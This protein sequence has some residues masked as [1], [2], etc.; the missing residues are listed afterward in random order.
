MLKLRH[1]TAALGAMALALCSISAFAVPVEVVRYA[2]VQA[3]DYG[4]QSAKLAADLA[5][6]DSAG[7]AADTVNAD[8][9]HEGHGFRQ[10]SASGKLR[11]ATQSLT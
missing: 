8:L 7:H 2:L 9:L 4:T 3:A 11:P 5:Y 6:M 10:E 1:I